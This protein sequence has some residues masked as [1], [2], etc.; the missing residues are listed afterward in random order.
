[1]GLPFAHHFAHLATSCDIL[2]HLGVW[3]ELPLGA[4]IHHATDAQ[5]SMGGGKEDLPQQHQPLG[6]KW[7]FFN[8]SASIGNR[9]RT[10]MD[11]LWLF[12]FWYTQITVSPWMDSLLKSFEAMPISVP[13]HACFF[14]TVLFVIFASEI[15]IL[16]YGNQRGES[17]P[18]WRLV[19][20]P[21]APCGARA[22]PHVARRY[23]VIFRWPGMEPLVSPA[24]LCGSEVNSSS[25]T[26]LCLNGF[27]PNLQVWMGKAL[28]LYWNWV[29]T[30]FKQIRMIETRVGCDLSCGVLLAVLMMIPA[31]LRWVVFNHCVA[32]GARLAQWYA[33]ALGTGLFQI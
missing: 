24:Q 9:T 15:I 26:W 10:K 19:G 31:V 3:G 14:S 11:C 28:I 2:R 18:W 27:T 22:V 23:A 21:A 20:A 8:D 17:E 25:P 7:P 33:E 4:T 5:W 32:R 16:T 1:M 29:Y 12:S 13:S 30:S 6:P